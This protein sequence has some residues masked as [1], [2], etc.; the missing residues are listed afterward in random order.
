MSPAAAAKHR[1]VSP[2]RACAYAVVRRVFEQ[3]AYADR[4]LAAE[5]KALDPRDR[6][7]AT[8]L[9]YGAVQRC[10]TLDHVAQ[11]FSSR[12]LERLFLWL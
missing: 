12:P 5:A 6:A 4:A 7:F 11:R 10:R 1:A 3:G 9:A 2:G 8:A